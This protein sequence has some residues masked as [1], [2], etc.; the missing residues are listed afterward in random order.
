MSAIEKYIS[1][2][3][4]AM[5][6]QRYYAQINAKADFDELIRDSAFLADPDGSAGLFP[7]HGVVHRRDVARQ[8]IVLLDTVHGVLIPRRSPERLAWMRGFCVLLACFHDIGMR[9]FSPFGR[10]MHPEFASQAVFDP[11]TEDIIQRL[12]HEDQA[13]VVPRLDQLARQGSLDQPASTIF[14]ELL[15]LSIGHSKSKMPKAVLND[16][17]ELRATLIEVISTDLKALDRRQMRRQARRAVPAAGPEASTANPYPFRLYRDLAHEAF[18]W[19]TSGEQAV[20]ELMVDAIDSVRVLR[21]AD[22]MRQ[23]GTTLQ[24][25]GNYEIFIDQRSGNAIYALR[26]GESQLFLLEL[27]GSL[28]S[29][30]ANVA[31]SEITPNGDVRLSLHRGSFSN[32]QATRYAAQ[33]VA[34]IVDDIQRDT[35]SAFERPAG[36]AV[37]PGEAGSAQ[38][39]ILLEETNDNPDFAALV[40]EQLRL[41]RPEVIGRMFIVP[42]LRDAAPLERERYLAATA[43][44]WDV[45][46]MDRTLRRVGR[47]GHLVEEMDAKKAFRHVRLTYVA[48]GETLI[49]ANAP[50]AFVYIPL[51]PGLEITPLGGYHSFQAQPW[52]PLGITGVIRGDMRNATVV[53]RQPLTLLMIPGNAYLRHWHRTHSPESLLRYIQSE[54]EES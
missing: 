38:M 48:E 25:S 14:R 47:A 12:L 19:L 18:C 53:A 5:L 2:E 21:A 6:D 50:S 27:H 10:R 32:T 15:A 43:P 23:R 51:S 34:L 30:E 42:S 22:A 29:G 3:V 17:S 49:E 31:S 16:L 37:G 11:E 41:I 7:D 46:T 44:D 40:R 4:Q 1:I 36:P 52:M 45:T 24:T 39:K 26:R 54:S 35:I 9:D 8:C 13:G 20:Q 28:F 33:C